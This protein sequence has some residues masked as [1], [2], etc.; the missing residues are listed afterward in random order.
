MGFIFSLYD[1]T[2]PPDCSSMHTCKLELARATITL[3]LSLSPS[4]RNSF[5]FIKNCGTRFTIGKKTLN[6]FTIS[7]DVLVFPSDYLVFSL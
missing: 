4:P 3:S 1:L 7:E 5:P 6:K 2:T